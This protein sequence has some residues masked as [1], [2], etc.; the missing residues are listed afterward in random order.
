MS[1]VVSGLSTGLLHVV[2]TVGGLTVAT[3]A[4]LQS[5]TRGITWSL[6]TEVAVELAGACTM[7]VGCNCTPA[8]VDAACVD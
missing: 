3:G 7:T 1:V 5:T 4:V 6:M 2:A 8:T